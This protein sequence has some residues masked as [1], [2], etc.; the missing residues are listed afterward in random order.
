MKPDGSYERALLKLSGEAFAPQ[1]GGGFDDER[2]RYLT[3]EIADALTVCP[4]LA[5][6]VGAGNILRGAQ[7]RPSGLE[8]LRADHAGMVATIVNALVLHDYLQGAGMTARVYSALPVQPVTIPFDAEKCRADL[9]DGCVVILAGGTGNPLFTTDTASALRGVQLGVEI[10]V[11]ATRVDGVYS[12]DPEAEP[13]AE[14]FSEI[15][16]SDVLQRDLRVMDL[17]A[18]SLCMEHGLPVRVLNYAEAGNIRRAL[19][20]E[21]VGTLIGKADDGH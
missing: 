19:A 14:L 18:V 20:G 11:K 13:D 12:A 2:L 3:C 7:F 1:G 6:V 10:V 8:R 17:C 16:F 21:A 5:I 4:Q 9:A 15:T